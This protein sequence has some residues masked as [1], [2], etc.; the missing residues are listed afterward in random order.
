MNSKSQFLPLLFLLAF[1]LLLNACSEKDESQNSQTPTSKSTKPEAKTT[2]KKVEV[3]QASSSEQKKRPVR[4]VS[5][6]DTIKVRFA[7]IGH[8]GTANVFGLDRTAAQA[9][10]FAEIILQRFKDEVPKNEMLKEFHEKKYGPMATG[11]YT[12]C[13]FGKAPNP[14]QPMVIPR[15]KQ[16]RMT[17]VAFGL[18]VGQLAIVPADPNDPNCIGV[19]VIKRIQ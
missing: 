8:E 10:E 6:P 2:V 18:E 9:Q 17:A 16:K 11:E 3:P 15:E 4:G 19:W 14:P 7:V 12:I 1:A 13:N 5:Q